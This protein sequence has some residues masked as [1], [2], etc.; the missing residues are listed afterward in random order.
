MYDANAPT[1]GPHTEAYTIRQQA[2]PSSGEHRHRY[3]H[4]ETIAARMAQCPLL[5][6]GYKYYEAYAYT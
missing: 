5:L 3:K 1:W 6:P 2:G 4:H